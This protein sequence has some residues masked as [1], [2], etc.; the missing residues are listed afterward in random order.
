MRHPFGWLT[1]EQKKTPNWSGQGS[2]GLCY[3]SPGTATLSRDAQK[4]WQRPT[5]VLEE[6]SGK[7]VDNLLCLPE[8]AFTGAGEVVGGKMRYGWDR[9]TDPLRCTE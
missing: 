1:E 3:H 6:T 4:P 7:H 2:E 9:F 8:K 5:P